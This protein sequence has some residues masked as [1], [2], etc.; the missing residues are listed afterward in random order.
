M[1]AGAEAPARPLQMMTDVWE[2]TQ[3]AYA[4][5]PG[6]AA[7][8]GAVGEYNGKFMVNQI[9]LRGASCA[10]PH[11]LSQ[12]LLPASALGVFWVPTGGLTHFC[13]QEAH[14]IDRSLMA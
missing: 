10:T 14:L 11:G 9:T 5:Y 12:F 13:G 6:F 8:E 7:A 4:P 1:P 3:S 2:W